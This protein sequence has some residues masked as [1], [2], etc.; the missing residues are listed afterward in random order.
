MPRTTV[1]S[2][3][4]PRLVYND[5]STVTKKRP[6][7]IVQRHDLK[8]LQQL[9]EKFAD[10]GAD[11]IPDRR[12]TDRRSPDRQR[13]GRRTKWTAKFPS[14]S[15]M[16][17]PADVSAEWVAPAAGDVLVSKT[18]KT[19]EEYDLS[20]VPGPVQAKYDHY[21]VA[22]ERARRF[23]RFAHADMW[24]TEDRRTFVLLGLYRPAAETTRVGD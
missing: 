2:R 19:E 18:P 15:F 14:S 12:S 21:E 11:V 7:L 9:R 8:R 22:V 10:E 5:H 16:V 3:P 17:V 24:Y 20:V 13:A 4:S 1:C 23:A 6:V